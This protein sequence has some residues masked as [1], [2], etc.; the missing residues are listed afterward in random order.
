MLICLDLHGAMLQVPCTFM[1]SVKVLCG[2]VHEN[3][4]VFPG[5]DFKA[6]F[7]SAP[8]QFVKVEH[9]VTRVLIE[10]SWITTSTGSQEFFPYQEFNISLSPLCTFHHWT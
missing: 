9:N 7:H 3:H 10:F 1:C 4:V 5:A 6:V 8:Q 2:I